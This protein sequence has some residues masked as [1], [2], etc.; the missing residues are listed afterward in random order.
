MWHLEFKVLVAH[1]GDASDLWE[2]PWEWG[3]LLGGAE[4]PRPLLLR[5]S[6]PQLAQTQ[7]SALLGR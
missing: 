2:E 6:P 4:A 7:P 5:P 1:L 3:G